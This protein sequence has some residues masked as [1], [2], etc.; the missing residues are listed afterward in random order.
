[1]IPMEVQKLGENE[2]SKIR[3][4]VQVRAVGAGK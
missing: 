4:L 3:L 1:M 2:M